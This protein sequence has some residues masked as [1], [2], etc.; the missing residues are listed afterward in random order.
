[1]TQPKSEFFVKRLLVWKSGKA[2]LDLSFHLGVN[3]IRGGN[4]VGKTTIMEFIFFALGG[5]IR[6]E[7][8][9]VQAASC[10]H[11]TIEVLVNGRVYSL[12]RYIEP[13]SR[14]PTLVAEK[15]IT[16][17]LNEPVDWSQYGVVRT[18]N[19]QSFS[20]LFFEL[21]GWPAHKLNKNS[22]LT[23][24]QIL[25]LIYVDQ[26]TAGNRILKTEA[27]FDSSNGKQAIGDFL[28]GVDDLGVFDIQQNLARLNSEF[29]KVKSQLD[30]VYSFISPTEGVLS[31]DNIREK[32]NA[33]AL[34][35]E[36]INKS[37]NSKLL[38]A[39]EDSSDEVQSETNDLGRKIAAEAQVLDQLILR[40]TEATDEIVESKVF[41]A[42]LDGRVKALQES[43]ETFDI[44][45]D[46]KF[47][48]CPSC[49]AE[50]GPT[51]SDDVCHL[52]KTTISESK[53]EEFYLAALNELHFQQKESAK[54]LAIQE[55]RFLEA[56]N[57][58]FASR[59]LL[60]SLRSEHRSLLVINNDR[61]LELTKLSIQLG[62]VKEKIEQLNS[63]AKLVS[64]V[65]GLQDRKNDLQLEI[66]VLSD[67]MEQIQGRLASRRQ[68]L[69]RSISDRTVSLIRQDYDYETAFSVAKKFRFSFQDDIMLVDDVSRF[70]ASSEII[71]KNSFH[72]ALLLESL[73][74]ENMRYPRILLLDNIEDKGMVEERSQ[75]FQN[76]VVQALEGYKQDFQVIMTTSMI[77]PNLE[78][79]P[80]CVGRFYPKGDHTLEFG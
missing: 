32:I 58:V 45:G 16:Q 28:L 9:T 60:S 76:V 43:K 59:N 54:V 53:R 70:S 21:M 30:A 17:V 56:N 61:M 3:I 40:Q 7:R 39:D 52:C 66:N 77:A 12:R 29:D 36:E 38:D 71:L 5:D 25:R 74:D 26:E 80:Y 41:L 20:Q 42:S 51:D 4:S 23:M 8:W 24:H 31:S 10:E 63:K 19:K 34:Q 49:L 37:I 67:E 18:E 33:H 50:V 73:T 79:T 57:Q 14:P 35:V 1:M 6:R 75:N 65:Q 44:F 46:I 22:N 68:S 13:G 15:T 69:E 78:G 55:Q 48:Y 64:S 11:V 27:S 62:S 47:R 72:L 2:V